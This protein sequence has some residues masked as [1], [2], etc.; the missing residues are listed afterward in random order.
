MR[1]V[2]NHKVRRFCLVLL[3]LFLPCLVYAQGG[4]P[5]ITNQ[6]QSLTV[7]QGTSATFTVEAYSATFINYQWRFNNSNI[8]GATNSSYTVTNA[9]STNMGDY[10]V[11]LTNAVGWAISTNAYLTVLSPPMITTQ[12]ANVTKTETANAGFNVVASGGTTL[13]YQ[14]RFNGTNLPGATDSILQLFNVQI[15]QSGPYSVAVSNAYGGVISSN[16]TLAVTVPPGWAAA[17]GDNTYTQSTIPPTSNISTSQVFDTS[18]SV[19]DPAEPNHCGYPPCA[20]YWLSYTPPSSGSLT[21]NTMGTSFNAVLAIYTGGNLSDLVPITCSANHG[22]AGE[23]VTFS[24]LGGTTYLVVIQGVDCA[25]GP[26]RVNFNL[27]VT[28]GSEVKAIA[29]GGSHSLVLK[30]NGIVLGW[31]DN[32]YG[33]TMPPPGLTDV[34]AVAAGY[35]HSL[36]SRCDGTVVA[37]GD[38]TFG[39][40]NVPSGLSNVVTIAAGAYH[41]LA[42]RKD[43]TVVAWGLNTDGQTDAPATLSN[44]VLIAAGFSHSLAQRTDGTIIGW[45]SNGSGEISPPIP[46]PDIVALSCGNHF[47]LVLTASGNVIGWG[48]D[49]FGETE[50]PPDL[51]NAVSISAGAFHALALR[52]NGTV[53]GWGR[54]DFG[55]GHVPFT[56]ATVTAIAAGRFHNV[57]LKGTGGPVIT[58]QPRSQHLDPGSNANLQ[59][60]AVGNGPLAFQWRLNGK[61]LAGATRSS[62]S[63]TNIQGG[64]SGTYSVIVSNSFGFALSSDAVLL[65]GN[66]II[67]VNGRVNSSGNF[68]F[69]ATGPGGSYEIQSSSDLFGWPTLTITNAP[70]GTITFIDTAPP[71]PLRRFYRVRIQ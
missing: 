38:N 24:A 15:W 33:Q 32:T 41:N 20:S 62:V 49:S 45:G 27:A 53:T 66:G 59:V 25:T 65:V 60:M 23:T 46:I 12:P 37:W 13:T 11:A 58:V 9:R 40:T 21:I 22:Q 7:T 39:Q 70:P 50:I 19:S 3:T 14:W 6:P 18:G 1:E 28:F 48:D 71:D 57:I 43:G 35:N 64:A 68:Q 61:N 51:S 17:W 29:A 44:V 16:A 31:G 34:K 5:I 54:D 30:T 69:D 2:R 36:A 56:N 63:L 26:A 47:S 8:L 10:S 52:D 55:Q 42:L 4:P 67:L